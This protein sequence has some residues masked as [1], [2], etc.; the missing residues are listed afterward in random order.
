[1]FCSL[2][3]LQ[4]DRGLQGQKQYM[5]VHPCMCACV[6][7]LVLR[8]FG[9]LNMQMQAYLSLTADSGEDRYETANISETVGKVKKDGEL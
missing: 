6:H 4:G 8:V 7:L 3:Q 2:C 9:S 5:H 1:M